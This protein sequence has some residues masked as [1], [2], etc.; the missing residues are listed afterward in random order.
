MVCPEGSDTAAASQSKAKSVGL[1]NCQS[2][3]GMVL[4][5]GAVELRNAQERSSEARLL[6]TF[7]FLKFTF[8]KR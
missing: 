2:S 6:T 7:A 1:R 3:L 4:P 8:K 5:L